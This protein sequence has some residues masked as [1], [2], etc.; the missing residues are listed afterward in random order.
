VVYCLRAHLAK[1]TTIDK[2]KISPPKIINRKEFTESYCPSE[3]S[4]TGWSLHL[5]NILPRENG[6]PSRL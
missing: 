1:K 3:E 4:N 6:R 5:S 2:G